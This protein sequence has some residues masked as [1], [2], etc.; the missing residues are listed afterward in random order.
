MPDQ[1]RSP[2][3]WRLYL[4]QYSIDV[5]RLSDDDELWEVSDE[6]RDGEWLGYEGAD[7]QRLVALEE[8]LGTRLPPSYR[9]FLGASDGWLNLGPFMS[10]MR[11]T[12]TVGWFR[13]ADSEAWHDLRGGDGEEWDDREFMDRVLLISGEGDS[14]YWLLDPDDRSSDDEW[15]GVRVGELESWARAP[16]RV[17]RRSRHARARF[18]RAPQGV[19]AGHVRPHP[20][21]PRE[22]PFICRIS[23]K[24]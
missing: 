9:S 6:Q 1:F 2:E 13:D 5:L 24:W 15:A 20:Y 16:L 18:V 22:A 7:E 8:R 10:S 19:A 11:T 3:R 12:D 4:K 14:Q 23:H 17:L 21:K